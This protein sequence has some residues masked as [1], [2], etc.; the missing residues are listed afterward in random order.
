MDPTKAGDDAHPEVLTHLRAINDEVQIAA[1]SMRTRH[2]LII[3]DNNPDSSN[4]KQSKEEPRV[5]LL[6]HD[7]DTK[8]N[9]KEMKVEGAQRYLVTSFQNGSL[10]VYDLRTLEMVKNIHPM[11]E[12]LINNQPFQSNVMIDECVTYLAYLHRDGK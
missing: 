2:L 12:C 4:P 5:T 11:S 3:Q 1:Y 10:S 8:G 9:L 7:S 6:Q